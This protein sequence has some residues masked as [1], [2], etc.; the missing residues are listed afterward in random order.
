VAISLA[1]GLLPIADLRAAEVSFDVKRLIHSLQPFCHLYRRLALRLGNIHRRLLI[2]GELIVALVQR[3]AYVV[4]PQSLSFN[5]AME[6]CTPVGGRT[7]VSL[8]RTA[9]VHQSFR[10]RVVDDSDS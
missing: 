10:G 2:A 8:L 3:A 7:W 4:Q 5:A 6:L 1:L 9:V